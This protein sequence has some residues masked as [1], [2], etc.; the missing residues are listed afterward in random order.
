MTV[1]APKVHIRSLLCVHI[2][3]DC[4]KR[5]F[6]ILWILYRL[7]LLLVIIVLVDDVNNFVKFKVL[8][9]FRKPNRSSEGNLK[10]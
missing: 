4:M 1:C 7:S 2:I 10:H 9:S 8:E 5:P 6:R 3:T